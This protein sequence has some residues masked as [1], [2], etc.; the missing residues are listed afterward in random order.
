MIRRLLL[1]VAPLLL[2][3]ACGA[4]HQFAGSE[5]NPPKPID[6]WTITDAR[7]DSFRL[8]DQRGNVVLLYFGYTNCPDFCPTT[9]GAWKQ[10]RAQ[11]G[12]DAGRVRFAMITVD[13]ERD[14]PD[15]L[16]RYLDHF[17]SSFVGLHPTPEQLE[18]L[19]RDYG[20]GVDSNAQ[21]GHAQH[22]DLDPTMHGTYTYVIDPQGRLRL[23][24]SAGSAVEPM[25]GDIRALLRE[26]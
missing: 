11:L 5:L 19:S 16:A 8:S 12:D 2:L 26:G 25:V 21:V 10:V 4:P 24:F 18:A 13:P 14:T 15:V 17:D 1:A 9:M 22:G 7:G 3:V 20:A 6:D 23:L